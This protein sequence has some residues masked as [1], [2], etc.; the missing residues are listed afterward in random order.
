MVSN[1]LPPSTHTTSGV[2]QL[3]GKAARY[4]VQ[5]TKQGQFS[6]SGRMDGT[7]GLSHANCC[8][9]SVTFSQPSH[10]SKLR[11]HCVA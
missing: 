8:F 9:C 6:P 1:I 4:S 3:R 10:C 5:A 11:L 7:R 2:T